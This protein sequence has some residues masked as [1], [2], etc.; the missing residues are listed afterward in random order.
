MLGGKASPVHASKAYFRRALAYENTQQFSEAL[1]DIEQVLSSDATN[2]V[3][4]TM[5]ER[6]Q[7]VLEEKQHESAEYR[8]KQLNKQALQAYGDGRYSEAIS[9]IEEALPLTSSLPLRHLLSSCYSSTGNPDK[10]LSVA[11]EI[12]QMDATNFKAIV[13]V[14]ELYLEKVSSATSS[15]LLTRNRATRRRPR[16]MFL[17][18]SLLMHRHNN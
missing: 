4:I 2:A 8:G 12:L 17:E 14:A 13:R 6:L 16:S 1:Q 10:A 3:A 15:V 18:H 9:Y 11:L 7:K 5:R